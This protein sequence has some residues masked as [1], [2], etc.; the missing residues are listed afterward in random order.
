MIIKAKLFPNTGHH[1]YFVPLCVSGAEQTLDYDQSPLKNELPKLPPGDVTTLAKWCDEPNAWRVASGGSDA[2]GRAWLRGRFGYSHLEKTRDKLGFKAMGLWC[3]IETNTGTSNDG[4]IYEVINTPNGNDERWRKHRDEDVK[5]T[6]YIE[7]D[8]TH[9]D[10]KRPT[11]V[12][13][14]EAFGLDGISGAIE[15]C[16]LEIQWLEPGGRPVPV[17]L[18]IDFGNSRTIAFGLEHGEQVA[19]GR[20]TDICK[21]I[22]FPEGHGDS[23]AANHS[24]PSASEIVPD[25]WFILE[26][27]IFS[28]ED[29][30]P[31]RFT[32]DEYVTETGAPSAMER[33]RGAQPRQV[34]KSIK[35]RVPHMFVE[36]SP[37]VLG[38]E[39]KRCLARSDVASGHLSF[40][41][42]P[43]RYV[44]DT[45]P[46]GRGGATYWFMNR[47]GGGRAP[48]RL[49][50]EM[51]RFLPKD[52]SLRFQS[53]YRG[54]PEKLTPPPAWDDPATRPLPAPAEPD[55]ARADAMVWTALSIMELAN[56]QIQSEAW[57]GANPV[58]R[59][60]SNVVITFPPGWTHREL[61][62]YW[63]AWKWARN[64]MFWSRSSSEGDK[65]PLLPSLNLDMTLDE[66]VASQLPIVFSEIRHLS[67]R[68]GEWVDLYGRQR[69]G[70]GTMRVLTIDIGGGTTDTSVVDYR[71][72]ERRAVSAGVRLEPTVLFTDS[73]TMAGDKLVKLLIE[74]ALLPELGDAVSA[75]PGKRLQFERA[76]GS[77]EA[78]APWPERL[79]RM[80]MTRA[81]FIPMVYQWLDDCVKGRRGGSCWTPVECG[82]DRVQIDE[83]NSL[84][85]KAGLPVEMLDGAAPFAVDQQRI[86]AIIRKWG[87]AIAEIHAHYVAVFQCDLVI[88]TG[89]PSELP[90]VRAILEEE[91]PIGS[92]RIVFAAGYHAGD[93]FPANDDKCR[94]PDAKMVTVVGA[95]LY[96]AIRGNL[97][98][99][100]Q[101]EGTA[102][103]PPPRNYWGL[104]PGHGVRFRDDE[105]LMEPTDDQRHAILPVNCSIA[106]ARFRQISPEPVYVLRWRSPKDRKDRGQP[107]VEIWLER[108]TTTGS[109]EPLPSEHLELVDVAGVDAAGR[110]IGLKDV[111]LHLRTLPEDDGHWLDGGKFEV[112]WRDAR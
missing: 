105:L 26:E 61:L 50:G 73:S 76:M 20:L 99:S 101:I 92:D 104:K 45:D 65:P 112:H 29:F 107:D 34:L 109:G 64:I 35:R 59:Y 77:G 98:E 28:A 110:E 102:K 82:A 51:L 87:K 68:P 96:Q 14:V 70:V 5:T 66:A 24:N 37:A 12:D 56:R 16:I 67:N 90:Q 30:T 57:R 89:K 44:W 2:D 88:V 4:Y 85:Q 103:A 83:L 1:F 60:L 63:Q 111:E 32:M 23:L 97:I 10:F 19:R 75:D 95:A 3:A 41:S 25:S 33:W 9:L 6:A 106:R 91:L 80:V 38:L 49:K 78:H 58:P 39:A 81:V 7:E 71:H 46:V 42:S 62:S 40:L 11:R 108:R 94:I 100:W 74:G 13:L 48:V 52:T 43:K 86:D 15:E 84:L 22:L 54:K 17:H 36:I 21:P 55:F 18:V 93:W 27:P 53:K 69:Q 47:R 8:P 31:P 72:R 79:K